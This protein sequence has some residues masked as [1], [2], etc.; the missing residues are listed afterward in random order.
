M[1]LLL[2]LGKIAPPPIITTRIPKRAPRIKFRVRFPRLLHTPDPFAIPNPSA[3]IGAIKAAV[4]NSSLSSLEIDPYPSFLDDKEVGDC[5]D[6]MMMMMCYDGM[7]FS[8]K[9]FRAKRLPV[10]IIRKIDNAIPII[11]DRQDTGGYYDVNL[12]SFKF[13]V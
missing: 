10:V 11:S 13:N 4:S 8:F 5:N 6:D 12:T 7:E 2:L 1:A 9:Y 3:V